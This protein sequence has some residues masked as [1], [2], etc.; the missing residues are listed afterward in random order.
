MTH[1]WSVALL[2]VAA[3]PLAAQQ[4]TQPDSVR[5]PMMGPGPMSGMMMDS[6][7]MQ[8][9]GPAMIGLMLYTPQHLL[10]R[11]DA[12]GLTADQIRRLTALRDASKT[13]HDAAMSAAQA[14]LRE[15]DQAAG[16]AA[17]DSG[18]LKTHFQAAH[19]AMGKAHW[20]M[21]ASAVQAR[22]VL[23]GAQRVK[24]QAWADSM[25][26]WMREHQKMMNP[27]RSQ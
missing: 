10:A 18:A 12:L 9:M 16:A 1:R 3:L 13:A 26:S 2:F 11:K 8:Q 23:T 5:R 21:L 15:M 6:P 22:T 4:P 25:H 20:A 19:D 14:H 24:V 17:P 7:L 27:T